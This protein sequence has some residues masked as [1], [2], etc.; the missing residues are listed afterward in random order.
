MRA[1][2]FDVSMPSFF[3]IIGNNYFFISMFLKNK[4]FSSSLSTSVIPLFFV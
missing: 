3:I 1:C 2:H 4:V